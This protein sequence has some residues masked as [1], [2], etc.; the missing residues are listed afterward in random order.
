MTQGQSSQMCCS[1][2][3]LFPNKLFVL[4][5]PL[6]MKHIPRGNYERSNIAMPLSVG[7]SVVVLKTSFSC[8]ASSWITDVADFFCEL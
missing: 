4:C 7:S 8:V 3:M 2:L 6:P 5:P 1:H